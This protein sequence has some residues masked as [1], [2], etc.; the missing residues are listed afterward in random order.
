MS[1]RS[2][3]SFTISDL[4]RFLGKSPVTLR[5]WERQGLISYPRNGRGDRRFAV[6]DIRR[7]L[8]SPTCIDRVEESRRRI[9]EATLTLLE[10]VENENWNSRSTV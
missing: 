7:V 6:E 10:I 2:K 8:E 5:G 3:F 1:A 4:A 9:C